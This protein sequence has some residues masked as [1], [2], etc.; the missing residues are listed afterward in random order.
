MVSKICY[1]CQNNISIIL[2]NV[3][4][5]AEKIKTMDANVHNL[6]KDKRKF[7]FHSKGSVE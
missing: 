6:A 7:L 4:I 3:E 5:S 1:V 2:D